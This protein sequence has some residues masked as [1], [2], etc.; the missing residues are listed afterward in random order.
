[1]HHFLHQ[2]IETWCL[3]FSSR[4]YVFSFVNDD[5]STLSNH[6]VAAIPNLFP[7]QRYILK[8]ELMP[9]LR[10]HI[11]PRWRCVS[12]FP[13]GPGWPVVA[14]KANCCASLVRFPRPTSRRP[15]K[16][17]GEPVEC[18]IHICRLCNTAF[19]V[20]GRSINTLT[21]PGQHES[22]L[23][24]NSQC[25]HIINLTCWLDKLPVRIFIT[26]AAVYGFWFWIP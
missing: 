2:C 17:S 22:L 19:Y 13:F 15:L 3:A 14:S 24:L 5:W 20:W 23:M 18:I 9:F 8:T 21:C 16:S 1:M 7:L 11:M 10:W 6:V 12:G 4:D 26:L 25:N